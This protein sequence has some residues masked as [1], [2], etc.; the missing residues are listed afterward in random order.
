MNSPQ[1]KKPL[2]AV[3]EQDFE[4]LAQGY[5]ALRGQIRRVIVGQHEIVE[6][7]LIALLC[8][9]H[10]LLVGVPGLAK[11]LLVRTLARCLDLDA[12]RI[13]FT[14]DMMPSDI[15]GAELLQTDA[16]TGERALRFAKGPIFA[17]LILADEI[18]RTPP[19]T[20][21]ALLE[22]MAE[23]QV[24][25]GGVT[26]RLEEPFVVV[27]T[28]NP[29]EQEGTYPLPEA[30]L[31]RFLF[32]LHLGYPTRAEERLIA[33]EAERILAQ[34]V[35]CVFNRADLIRYRELIA[36]I[37]VSDHVLDYAVDLVR[38]TRPDEASCPEETVRPYIA[39]GAG[40]RAGQH[41]IM[42]AKCLAALEGRPTPCVND[43][44]RVGLSVLRH[45]LVLNY[46]AAGEN[47]SADEMVKRLLA[48]IAE[49]DY[50]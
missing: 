21:A 17:N 9:G 30:Q 35:E 42:A 12:A 10:T 46:A 26:H 40:P 8:Q 25:V 32:S 45:R 48:T 3:S 27:A 6:Q 22:A 4:D 13:Q 43:V 14:P 23:H 38:A 31:D 18:N 5:V 50:S 11:T 19:K 1:V 20:Q 37:P 2:K 16:S 7:L 41:L 44:K 47:L 28:Q 29:I 24:T 15:M 33:G 36:L 39:W 34:E 49:Q